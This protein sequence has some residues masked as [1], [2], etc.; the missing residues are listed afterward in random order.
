MRRLRA[1]PLV[2][3]A[4]RLG[5]KQDK[6]DQAKW[7]SEKAILSINGEKFHDWVAYRGGGGSID[8]VKH[9]L[10]VGNGAAMH[11]LNREFG[12]EVT[13]LPKLARIGSQYRHR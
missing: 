6:S 9:I 7:K 1:I 12:G 3:V 8:L 11:W 13:P 4:E 5:L 10:G 2:E